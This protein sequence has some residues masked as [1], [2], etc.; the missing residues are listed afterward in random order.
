MLENNP[1]R[2]TSPKQIGSLHF[3]VLI[4]LYNHCC[5]TSF[6]T[7]NLNF[8]QTCSVV[9]YLLTLEVIIDSPFAMFI[10]LAFVLW[11]FKV[12]MKACVYLMAE[13]HPVHSS[14]WWT[15]PALLLPSTLSDS[16]FYEG[17]RNHNT[18]NLTTRQP[19][20]S[21]TPPTHS[22]DP[23]GRKDRV[24]TDSSFIYN[25]LVKSLFL[26]VLFNVHM[27]VYQI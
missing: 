23:L 1:G 3:S 19:V 4:F 13:W 9:T 6:L 11:Q 16:R 8:N 5:F 20:T 17:H 12:N 10:R 15:Q 2:F 18:R 7:V 21:P 25:P 14:L 24:V 27:V 22:L 26:T